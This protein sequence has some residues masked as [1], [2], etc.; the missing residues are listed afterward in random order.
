MSVL[1][2]LRSLDPTIVGLTLTLVV[3]GLLLLFS[4]TVAVGVQ[5]AGDSLFFVKNQL[6]K[7]VIPGTFA[8]L[9]AALIDYRTWRTWALGAL[10][11]SI[12]LLLLVYVPGVGVILNGARGWIRIAGLQFQPSEIVKVS[13]IVYLAAWLASR[14][15]D[16][17]RKLETGLVPFLLA[18]GSVMFLLIM[19]PDTGSMMVLVGTSLT[20]YFLSGAPVSWFVLL[21]ALG[22]GLLALLIKISPYRAARFMVF[23]RPELDPKGIGY[24]I[25]Q[26]VLAIGSGG[27]LG[28]GYGQSR[29][30]YLYLP[31]VESDSIVAVV[32]EELG[33]LAICLLLVLFGALVWRCFSIARES[34]DPFATYLAA[35]V[36]M[37]LVVQCVMNI[38]SMT[39]LLPITGV[40]LPF[41]SHGGTA[42]VMIM[43]CMG[44]IAGIPSRQSARPS[45]LRPRL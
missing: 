34:K 38:G 25:N 43:G 10:V 23:L 2:R 17:V 1:D 18:L 13:F 45:S 6:I 35:G 19:Q 22:S 8:F 33:F 16:E 29:Q 36:G 37:M 31:E 30:K 9:L 21:C 24:H 3:V 4:A 39:G 27:W 7:G 20:M 42:M 12:G 26:A 5:R 32:A 41:V 28:L 15:A 11:V 44:L 14:K 40:T